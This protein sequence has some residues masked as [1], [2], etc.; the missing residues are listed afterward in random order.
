MLEVLQRARHEADVA[1]RDAAPR[2]QAVDHATGDVGG[3]REAEI[4][5][6][7]VGARVDAD[8]PAVLRDQRAAAVARVDGRVGLQPGVERAG[9]VTSHAAGVLEIA[10]VVRDDAPGDRARQAEGRADGVHGLAGKERI[11][12]AERGVLERQP[13][14]LHLVKVE[15]DE[16]EVRPVVPADQLRTDAL[17]AGQRDRDLHRLRAGDVG[18]GEHEAVVRQDHARADARHEAARP[19]RKG[20]L[21]HVDAHHGLQQPVEILAHRRAGRGDHQ[22][23]QQG[24]KPRRPDD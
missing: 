23:H 4:V 12:I 10:A 17:Q 22:R 16:G 3:N 7:H 14:V 6:A 18:V 5:R 1:P 2:H 8:H 21:A 9:L 24:Q 19:F 20:H 13:P 15:A 11:G